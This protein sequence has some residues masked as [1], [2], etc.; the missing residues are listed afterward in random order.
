MLTNLK[1]GAEWTE[2]TLNSDGTV[3]DR[4]NSALYSTE[5]YYYNAEAKDGDLAGR[6]MIDGPNDAWQVLLMNYAG[7]EQSVIFEYGAAVKT[8]LTYVGLTGT[9]LAMAYLF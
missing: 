1:N 7:E 2:Q 4:G 6:V 8:V 9:T 3:N 5:T